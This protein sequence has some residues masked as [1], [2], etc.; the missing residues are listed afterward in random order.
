MFRAA[1]KSSLNSFELDLRNE[2]GLA[3]RGNQPDRA[4]NAVRAHGPLARGI[5][6]ETSCPEL[7]MLSNAWASHDASI[8]LT[9]GDWVLLGSGLLLPL[10]AMTRSTTRPGHRISRTQTTPRRRKRRAST[11]FR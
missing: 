11:T 2:N 8:V 9:A 4:A 3:F 5:L 10:F 1:K 6:G 7:S